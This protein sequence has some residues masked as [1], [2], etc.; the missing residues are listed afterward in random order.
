MD[1]ALGVG[2]LEEPWLEAWCE[3]EFLH[4]AVG[5]LSAIKAGPKLVILRVLINYYVIGIAGAEDL[6][7]LLAVGF[8]VVAGTFTGS[9]CFACAADVAGFSV[10]LFL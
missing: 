6:G 8:L 1:E 10:V 9:C 7:G 2:D 4:G 3:T 5:G